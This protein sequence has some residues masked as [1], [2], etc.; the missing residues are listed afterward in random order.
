MVF[1]DPVDIDPRLHLI[2]WTSQLLVHHYMSKT[3]LHL[4]PTKL[5][6]LLM[7]FPSPNTDIPAVVTAP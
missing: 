3:F 7:S 4:L 2:M 1:I 5:L 6:L